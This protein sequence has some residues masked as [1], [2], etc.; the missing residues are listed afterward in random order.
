MGKLRKIL[1]ILTIICFSAF[2]FVACEEYSI[3]KSSVSYD[4][5][6]VISGSVKENVR[7]VPKTEK[8]F[9][10]SSI[11]LSEVLQKVEIMGEIK[12]LLILTHGQKGILI[13]EKCIPHYNFVLT[14]NGVVKLYTDL[15]L[16]ENIAKLP[17]LSISE[18]LISTNNK[19]GIKR[20]FE[21]STDTLEYMTLLKALG[22]LIK[23]NEAVENEY[24]EITTFNTRIV[25]VKKLM[26]GHNSVVLKFKDDSL[27]TVDSDSTQKIHWSNG[28][29]FLIKDPKEESTLDNTK[30]ENPIV[31]LDYRVSKQ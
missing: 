6:F 31:E 13:N 2:S 29:L 30:Y 16:H 7:Y 24:F 18:I 20:I 28:G 27:L 22:M 15:P 8:E 4:P 12:S 19:C 25:S 9:E 21:N 26:A 5:S 10:M 14:S 17:L 11:N 3:V 23:I 1:I